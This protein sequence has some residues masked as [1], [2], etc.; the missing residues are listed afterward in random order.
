MEVND[1]KSM[2]INR[3]NS[4]MCAMREANSS[5][6]AAD[7]DLIKYLQEK[8]NSVEVNN[9]QELEILKVKMA[10]LHSG[11]VQGLVESHENQISSLAEQVRQLEDLVR[12]SREKLH[13]EL[14][15]K[16]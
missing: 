2:E 3:L 7:N 15:H 1:L 5:M 9:Q 10:H 11:D 16:T 8:L 4:E 12:D 6:A 13:T 14:V